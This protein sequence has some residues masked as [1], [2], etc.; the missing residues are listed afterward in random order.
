MP[1]QQHRDIEVVGDDQQVLMRGQRAC[2]LFGGGADIDEQRAAVGD[3]R[4]R[5]GAD[6]L[7]LLGGDEAARFI[8]EVLDAGGDDGAAMD[9][10]QRAVIA[11][12]VEILADGLRRDLEAPGEIFHHHPAQGAG[13][14]EDFG[15]AVGQSG[16]GGTLGTKRPMVRRFRRPVNAADRPWTPV[17]AAQNRAYG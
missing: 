13:D 5:G 2:D 8:G 4:R 9:P 17:Y 1:V 15:L 12:I 6:R 14:V 3:Q 16:H 10:G 7:L 11:E